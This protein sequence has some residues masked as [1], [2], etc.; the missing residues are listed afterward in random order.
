MGKQFGPSSVCSEGMRAE[1]LRIYANAF[2][3]AYVSSKSAR[4]F[5]NELENSLRLVIL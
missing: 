5:K 3:L 4:A 2:M 1:S